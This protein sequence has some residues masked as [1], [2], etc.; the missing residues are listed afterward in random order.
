MTI[1]NDAIL[2]F[3]RDF[4]DGKESGK[5]RGPLSLGHYVT[6]IKAINSMADIDDDYVWDELFN[7]KFKLAR[8]VCKLC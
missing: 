3:T 4:P 7:N 2:D 8:L 1:A 5:S 6:A